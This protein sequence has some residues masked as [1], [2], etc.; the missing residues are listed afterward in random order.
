V[1]QGAARCLL[2]LLLQQCTACVHVERYEALGGPS[3]QTLLCWKKHVSIQWYF[4]QFL[5]CMMGAVMCGE[6]AAGA[7][8]VVAAAAGSWLQQPHSQAADLPADMNV[9]NA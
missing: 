4:Q 5:T 1:V 6:G 9:S 8:A 3:K 7:A 2:T